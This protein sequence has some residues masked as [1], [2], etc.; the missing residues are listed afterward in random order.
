MARKLNSSSIELL[1]LI[2]KAFPFRDIS[3]CSAISK[4]PELILDGIAPHPFD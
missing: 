4:R 3:F 2:I 1:I